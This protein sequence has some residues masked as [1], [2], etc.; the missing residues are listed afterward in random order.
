MTGTLRAASVCHALTNAF[1]PATEE[2]T[3]RLETAPVAAVVVLA[4]AVLAACAPAES[5]APAP[6]VA[7]TP[8]PAVETPL[9]TPSL[10]AYGSAQATAF[11]ADHS[12]RRP[13]DGVLLP[14]GR[15]LLGDQLHGLVLVADDG[16]TRPFGNLSAAGY[17]HAPPAI[18]GGANGV[19][20]EPD[21]S[22]VLMSD[23][24]RGGIYCID[25]ATETSE[26]L[27][28]HEFGV[29]MARR[30]RAGGLWFSQSSRNTPERGEEELWRN[31]AQGTTE[32]AILHLAAG[33]A[34]GSATVAVDGITFANGIALDEANG[35]LYAAETIGGRILRYRMDTATGTLAERTVLAEGLAPDNIELDPSG[36]LWIALPLRTEI[37]T[38]DPRSGEQTSM[39]RVA[40]EQTEATLAAIAERMAEGAPW[41]DLMTPA[42]WAPAPG[43]VTGMVL[44][45]TGE[46]RYVT[47]LG[48]AVIRIGAAQP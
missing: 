26:L 24:Y 43:A 44:S 6:A 15:L 16:S 5:P 20:L 39:Y 2:S 19:T 7:A 36:R 18:V 10:P 35:Y 4:C 40:T 30:D 37:I 27:Y 14:D 3:M 48:T 41:L 12:L 22:H 42:L 31:I 17:Q 34:A 9:A 23:V 45:P 29:N 25:T 47:G 33:G 32:G 46:L 28:Q 38:L 13:E 8:S 21:G 11:P 1:C